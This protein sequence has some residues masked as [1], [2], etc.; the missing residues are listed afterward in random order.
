[1][2]II[3]IVAPPPRY[4]NGSRSHCGHI[5]QASKLVHVGVWAVHL[6]RVDEDDIKGLL[7]ILE[8]AQVNSILVVVVQAIVEQALITD[9]LD[10][11]YESRVRIKSMHLDPHP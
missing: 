11:V 7:L 8:E 4:V 5:A 6:R 10:S 2:D 9:L 1:M 3:K